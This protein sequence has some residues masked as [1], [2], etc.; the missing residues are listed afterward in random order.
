ICIRDRPKLSTR[1]IDVTSDRPVIDSIAQVVANVSLSHHTRRT[2]DQ[3]V[4]VQ[5]L[6][7]NGTTMNVVL[8]PQTVHV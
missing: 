1:K 7:E 8:A 3:E 5:V 6:D 4:L 2:V